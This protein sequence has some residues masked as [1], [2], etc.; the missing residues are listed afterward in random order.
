MK[1]IWI[2]D[3]ED[4]SVRP[5]SWPPIPAWRVVIVGRGEGW[6]RQIVVD[7][8]HGFDGLAWAINRLVEEEES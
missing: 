7:K 8:L 5:S 2:D 4:A 1:C 3:L 6:G